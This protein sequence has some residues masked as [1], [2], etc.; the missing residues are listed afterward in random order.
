MLPA[1]FNPAHAMAAEIAADLRS[2][3]FFGDAKR[4][5]AIVQ[6]AKGGDL[7]EAVKNHKL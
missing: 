4:L 2:A 7:D 3:T 6:G 1:R 5:A